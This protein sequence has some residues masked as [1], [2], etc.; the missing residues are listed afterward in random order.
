MI[1]SCLIKFKYVL[2]QINGLLSQKAVDE[3]TR[4]TIIISPKV[5]AVYETLLEEEGLAGIANLKS[6]QW[7]LILMDE[8]VLSMELPFLFKSVFVNK[9]SSLLPSISNTLWTLFQVV[10]KPSLF[11]SVGKVSSSILEM[12][13]IFS[14]TFD[15]DKAFK[16]ESDFGA[17]LVMDRD[18]DY[19]SGLLTPAT[20]SG[21]LHEIFN[22][23][24]GKLDLDV[25]NNK[26]QQ[27]QLD[28]KLPI[29]ESKESKVPKTVMALDS[30]LDAVYSEI[31]YRHFSTVFSILNAKVKALNS[32][33]VNIGDLG[34]TQMKQ[35]VSTKLQQI[36]VTKRSL[37]NH[38]LACEAIV[39][40]LGDKFEDIQITERSMLY[41]RN[42]KSNLSYVD[43]NFCTDVNMYT[44]LRLLCLLTLTQ[45]ITYEEYNGLITKYLHAFGYNFLYIFQSLSSAGLISA[46]SSGKLQLGLPNLSTIS[47]RLPRW[48]NNFQTAAN[49]LKQLPSDSE[50][51]KMSD[52]TCPSYVF[53]GSYV[54]TVVAISKIILTSENTTDLFAKLASVSEVKVGGSLFDGCRASVDDLGD[55]LSQINMDS[56]SGTSDL[57]IGCKDLKVAANFLKGD[58]KFSLMPLRPKSL[59]V[60]VVGGLT[61]AEVAA[62]H[63]LSK[64]TGGDIVLATDCLIT[65]ESLI[66]AAT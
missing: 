38:V 59:L 26:F 2:D 60:F 56:S 61:Q 40:N 13:D 20:Y 53:S 36:I 47:D 24:C 54:P 48:Q 62:C 11:V 42:K 1:P 22:V 63:L 21:L 44:S 51:V 49:K 17:L 6:F 4:I 16:G 33:G 52:P 32:D 18:Q 25:T 37:A 64:L 15:R 28:L 29:A 27:G 66:Q 46:P 23:K 65:G 8:N 41:N 50:D 10:G 19:A 14:E 45:G 5:L 58:M 34:I 30:E 12:Y 7:E 57:D 9:D 35:Y 3:K 39:A 31:R 55:K 43:T